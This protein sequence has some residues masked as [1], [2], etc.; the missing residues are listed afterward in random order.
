MSWAIILRRMVRSRRDM[1]VLLAALSLVTG[2]FAISPLYLRVLGESALRYTVDQANP[3]AL[4]LILTA[5]EPLVLADRPVITAELGAIA[6][7]IESLTMMTGIICN[8]EVNGL[9]FGDDTYRAYV[10]VSYER[11]TERFALQ[12]GAFPAGDGEAAVTAAIAERLGLTVGR[13]LEFYPDTPKSLT[14][15]LVGILEPIAP[16]DRFWLGQNVVLAG[17]IVDVTENFQRFDFGLIVSEAAYARQIVPIAPSGTRY[18]WVVDVDTDVLRAAELTELGDSLAATERTLRAEYLTAVWAG[19]L[20]LLLSDFSSRLA[21]AEG[22]VILFA[23]AVL[24]L[25]F[26]QLMT[27]TALLLERQAVEWSS[28]SS[29]GGSAGQLV[30]MQAGTMLVLAIAAFGLGIG[31]A[32]LLVLFVGH[33]SPLAVVIGDGLSVTALPASSVM[34]S[35]AAALLAVIALTLPALPAARM[36]IL[37]LKQSVSRPPST[38][39]WSRYFL[40][41]VL[42]GLG[43]ALL[44]RLYF[45]FGGAGFEDLLRDP[46][47]LIR[48]ITARGA[49]ESGILQDPFNLASVLLLV[50]GL[51][52]LWL[53]LFP[54]VMRGVSDLLSRA[55]GL[56]APLAVWQIARD[57]GHYGQLVMVLIGTLAIGTASLA[58]A[59][60]HDAGSWSTARQTTGG[61]VALTFARE[62]PA[63][64]DLPGSVE[65]LMRYEVSE[66]AGNVITSLFGLSPE[67]FEQEAGMA[68][69]APPLPGFELPRDAASIAM[70]VYA[71][72]IEGQTV[73]T[74]LGLELMDTLGV[75]RTVPLLTADETVTGQFVDYRVALPD[76]SQLPYRLVGLRL[77]SRIGSEGLDH[78]LFVDEVAYS[79]T[80]GEIVA[81]DGFERST[82]P[83]WSTR[84]QSVVGRPLQVFAVPSQSQASSGRYALRVDY[85]V[86]ARGIRMDEPVISFYPVDGQVVLPVILSDD[87]AVTLGVRAGK[88]VLTPGDSGVLTLTFPDGE[89]EL[90]FRVVGVQPAFPTAEK[91]FIIAPGELLRRFLNAEASPDL[92]YADNTLWL[93]LPD[94]QIDATLRSHLEA[95]PE[96][97]GIVE[98]WDGYNRLLREPLP[99]AVVGV[100]FAGF[101]VSLALGL[102]DF[103]VYLM[104]TAARRA[105][106]FAVLRALGWRASRVW[107]LLA[108]EQAVLAVPALGIGVALGGMLAY[109]LLPFLALVGDEVLRL[110]WMQVGGLLAAL[111]VGFVALLTWTALFLARVNVGQALRLG[112]E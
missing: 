5:E 34:L 84:E 36:S 26:Y 50:T 77:M 4:T 111:I 97:T 30:M 108:V 75:I 68:V 104:M 59:A 24:M 28:I 79:T 101:W 29:R 58:L 49:Q 52:L 27:T 69:E 78:V 51:A 37:R 74:R 8:N 40:D 7:G 64:A 20:P 55:N 42:I 46:S 9:C 2:F 88:R 98:A 109:L 10:P 44:L 14:M 67:R 95:L 56:V 12:A 33:F 48:L 66:R 102:L 80:T 45:L 110:P 63:A 57:P 71:E 91:R 112:E 81:I 21:A 32:V 65:A 17:Q 86:E 94:R 105:T 70:K 11:L 89:R 61:E 53:R 22:T 19:G 38:P 103:A 43:F 39:V 16:D 23:G 85:A 60:T 3:R 73:S 107:G 47:A 54:L 100:L 15:T 99:N 1:L 92:N 41:L 18:D 62:V 35:A 13:V 90:V 72:A 82:A 76:D 25:L 96:L 31:V 93:T 6:A 106:T 87:L 83:E